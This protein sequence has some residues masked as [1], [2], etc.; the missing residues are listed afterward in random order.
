M[1]YNFTCCFGWVWNFVSYYERMYIEGVWEQD[2][3]D[4]IR[5]S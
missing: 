5:T 2:A 4:N 1:N 3:D